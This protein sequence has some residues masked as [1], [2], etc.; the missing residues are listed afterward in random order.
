MSDFKKEIEAI[1][2][3]AGRTVRIQEFQ[4]LLNLKNPGMI[5]ESIKELMSEYA[6]RESPLM[7]VEE[8]EGW[9]LTVKE[10]LLPI[11]QRIN[12]H[13]E[14]SKTIIET[15]SVIAWK[16]PA[17]QSD[18]IK[19]RTNKA[20]EHIEELEHLG[21]VSKERHGRSFLLKVTQKFLDYFDL[22]N[23]DAIKDAFKGFKDIEAAAKKK[24]VQEPEKSAEPVKEVGGFQA[25]SDELP[26]IRMPKPEGNVEVYDVP[27]EQ[28]KKEEER[29][30]K[31]EEEKAEVKKAQPS[32]PVE[33][34]EEKARRLAR[35]ILGEEAPKK[36][37][38]SV[39]EKRKLHPKLEEF[40]AGIA[41]QERKKPE[42]PEAAEE[43]SES[44]SEDNEEPLTEEFP[45]Q[46]S[47]TEEE[48]KP[49]R[50]R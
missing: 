30:E 39:E 36:Q 7:I 14:L 41:E 32:R 27:P 26:P 25:F 1:L 29:E 46:F 3:S 28:L 18:V 31:E 17:L 35:E 37:E 12:P 5:R 9:K 4:L 11:V 19:I 16:Q 20:Y 10:K 21:F 8:G 45:G 42:K 48:E 38:P 33:N 49:K 50:K 40:I 47:E 22:P 6:A 34:P 2:F 44:E 15:L 24:A 13:T 43:E 23:T